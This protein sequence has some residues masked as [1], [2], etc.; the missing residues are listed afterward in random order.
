MWAPYALRTNSSPDIFMERRSP[1]TLTETNVSKKPPVGRQHS[2]GPLNRK[3]VPCSAHEG[4]LEHV[5][6]L[7]AELAAAKLLG[8]QGATGG[9]V[10]PKKSP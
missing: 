3:R 4:Q 5:F 7:Q 6:C 2:L 10:S 1:E 9:S 8:P